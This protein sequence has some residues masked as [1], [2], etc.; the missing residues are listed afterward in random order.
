MLVTVCARRW[1]V[2]LPILVAAVLV[3]H[4][5][6][7]SQTSQWEAR[8][9]IVVLGNGVDP[10]PPA[11]G[12]PRPYNPFGASSGGARLLAVGVSNFLDNPVYR[13]QVA[14]AGGSSLY[15]MTRGNNTAA[16]DIDVVADSP[17]RAMRTVQVT[18]RLA[19]SLATSTQLASKAPKNQ[20]LQTM[21]IG[22]S[23]A[24]QEIAPSAL[25]TLIAVGAAGL[26]AAICA[27]V[28]T[29]ALVLRWRARRQ[30]KRPGGRRRAGPALD[31]LDL[32]VLAVTSPADGADEDRP[33]P[34]PAQGG[35]G[36]VGIIRRPARP[37]RSRVTAA[38]PPETGRRQS[39]GQDRPEPTTAVLS[40]SGPSPERDGG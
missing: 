14:D 15:T 21:A 16:F 36:A 29:E 7:G 6:A 17:D 40:G 1:Y 4:S 27:A 30:R 9:T 38:A 22:T 13:R 10:A 5:L 23:P 12:Q 35:E 19:Q 33:V 8:T 31:P 2:M 26:L 25:K 18:T 24:A 28:L 34:V 11:E 3:G 32:P 39:E 20:L 37:R